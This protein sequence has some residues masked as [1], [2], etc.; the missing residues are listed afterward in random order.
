M[1]A[2][3]SA[4]QVGDIDPHSV[5]FSET[6][7]DL[8]GCPVAHGSKYGGFSMLN[9]YQDVRNASRDHARFSSENDIDGTGNGGGGF[10]LPSSTVRLGIL[11]MDPPE[12]RQMRGVLTKTISPAEIERYEPRMRSLAAEQIEKAAASGQVDAVE[13]MGLPFAA[14]ISFEFMGLPRADWEFFLERLSEHLRVFP[15]SPDFPAVQVR[16]G[17]ARARMKEIIGERREEPEKD[18]FS[19]LAFAN[20]EGRGLS[21]EEIIDLAWQMLD[22]GFDT[23]GS[24]IAFSM[25]ALTDHPEIRQQLI[26]D[27]SLISGA[28]E[29]F[30]R[31][32]S[33]VTTVGRTVTEPVEVAGETLPAGERVLLN[34][35]SANFDPEFWEDPGVID[36]ERSPNRHMTFGDGIHK[37]LGARFTRVAMRVF[38]EELLTL[39]PQFTVA[40]DAVATRPSSCPARGFT[41]VPATLGPSAG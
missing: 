27:P 39:R 4:K 41:A 28:V 25:I 10:L 24:A 17:E 3:P 35:G 22:A 14:W 6:F 20:M 23:V 15:D 26:D 32:Y 7:K 9:G 11:E 33:I 21:D 34:L 38:L 29:E 5:E 2:E 13:D 30:L 8:S 18:L 19:A 31:Y 37:C 12:H 36:I 40:V 16:M 1:P